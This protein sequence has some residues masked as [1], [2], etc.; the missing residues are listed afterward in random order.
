VE[1]ETDR[2]RARATLVGA[3]AV[4]LWAALALFTVAAR[5][6][7]P[8]ELLALS[9]G[10]ACLSGLGL[11][12]RRGPAALAELRQPPAPWLLA[13]G[14]LFFY[15]AL[16]F[17]ALSAAPPA[18]ASLIAYLW[19]LFIVLFAA[20]LPGERLRL[21][22]VAG[23]GLGLGGTAVIVLGRDG[24]AGGGGAALGFAAAFGCA[25]VWSG[26]SVLNRR[27]AAVPSTMLVGVCGA[28]AAAGWACHLALEATVAPRAGQWA[29]VALLG[30]GPTGLAFL[31]W[32]H[33]TK[34]G[35]LPVLGGLAYLAP[36]LSTLLLIL[37][38]E[39][40][41]GAALA[42]AAALIVGGAVLATGVP[43]RRSRR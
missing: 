25:L 38:G 6:L 8:F 23:A 3:G 39:A 7:P 28:V 24:G 15:H 34:R 1:Q 27:F 2:G 40:Q 26:Y 13:F 31:A 29:A 20:A 22:H 12:A 17:Y 30:L 35:S 16:Y 18:R 19:P 41:G 43:L 21:R 5:G 33:A 14:G 9:F 10:V 11:L 4:V 36:L 32:D 42:A 37:T